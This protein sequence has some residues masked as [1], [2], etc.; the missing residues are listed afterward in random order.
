M[1]L[2]TSQ[3]SMPASSERRIKG[4][5]GGDESGEDG[6]GEVEGSLDTAIET[7]ASASAMGEGVSGMTSES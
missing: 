3:T 7:S 4:I 5:G 6:A 2:S 1:I